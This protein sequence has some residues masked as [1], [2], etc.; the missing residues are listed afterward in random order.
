MRIYFQNDVEDVEEQENLKTR[1]STREKLSI[2]EVDY[3]VDG[4]D[5]LLYVVNFSNDNGYMLLS[6]ANSSFPVIAHSNTGNLDLR[7]IDKASPLYMVVESY[8]NKIRKELSDPSLTSSEYFEEWKDLGKKGYEYEIEPNNTEPKSAVR[9]RRR[10]SSGKK[11]IYPY[12]GIELDYWCQEGG[13]NFYAQNQYPIGC[14]AIATGMLMYD[15]SQ[16]MLGNSQSTFPGFVFADKTDVKDV[17]TGTSVARKLRQIADSIPGYNFTPKFSGA[18]PDNITIGLHKLGYTKAE[19]VPYDFELLYKN[20]TF[21]GYNYFGQETEFQ[22]GVLL[23]AYQNA[24]GGGH[25][26]FCD[27]YYEQSYTVKKKFL[28][29]KVKSWNEYDDRIYMNWG[30]GH[31]K[32]NGWYCATASPWSSLDKGKVN[33]N[34]NTFMYINLS[35]YEKPVHENH[36]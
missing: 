10:H 14:P 9:A 2:K 30:W 3:I 19:K 8:K 33:L 35:H 20:F 11:T 4:T 16:R 7:D 29:I 25:I 22:R 13:Y 18:L 12:T 17:A 15:T 6:G 34:H 32:G 31:D 36:H 5:T 24:W 23:A 28:G 1:S 27:G 21:K 26:W